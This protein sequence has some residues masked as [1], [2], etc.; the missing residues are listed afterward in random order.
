MLKPISKSHNLAAVYD[1]G[2]NRADPKA[3]ISSKRY[4]CWHLKALSVLSTYYD[5]DLEPIAMGVRF[6]DVLDDN[7][8]FISNVVFGV[9]KD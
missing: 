8:Q 1:N 9:T 3:N 5:L 2:S 6:T 4:V 7:L